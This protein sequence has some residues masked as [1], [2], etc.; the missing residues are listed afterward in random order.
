M[1]N[2]TSLRPIGCVVVFLI[3][4]FLLLLTPKSISA[5]CVG[6][7]W[8]DFCH[9]EY[10]CSSS[11]LPCVPTENDGKCDQ[12]LDTLEYRGIC[13]LKHICDGAIWTRSCAGLNQTTCT[14]DGDFGCGA[15]GAEVVAGGCSWNG[16]PPAGCPAGF[17]LCGG[18]INACRDT[19][20][21]CTDHINNECGSGGSCD[22]PPG[23]CVVQAECL[24]RG[25]G[26]TWGG[27]GGGWC[28]DPGGPCCGPCDAEGF[29]TQGSAFCGTGACGPCQREMIKRSNITHQFC[30]S[31][32]VSDPTCIVG[33]CSPA[34]GQANG[35]SGTC[36]DTDAGP[37]PLVAITPPNGGT[38]TYSGVGN[39]NVSW[40]T[41]NKADI[42]EYELYPAGESCAHPQAAC[43]TSRLDVALKA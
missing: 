10:L 16:S 34:C 31:F 19:S 33:S 37:P 20:Q 13:E 11:Q 35:C 28:I 21:S 30:G 5:Q 38:L 26:W 29:Y 8:C 22:A 14:S 32:C 9:D 23:D 42:Y 27:A 4:Y 2:L 3:F 6:D 15:V 40:T 17:Q 41:A 18:C 12:D 25:P 24:A 39:F 7:Y 1:R 36:P 43:G